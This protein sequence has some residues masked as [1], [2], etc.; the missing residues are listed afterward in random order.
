MPPASPGPSAAPAAG[1]P[2]KTL[3]R[4]PSSSLLTPAYMKTDAPSPAPV[5]AAAAA[6]A[7]GAPAAAV[8][9]VEASTSVP[10]P[11]MTAAP[12]SVVE[13]LPMPAARK[14]LGA[15]NILALTSKGATEPVAENIL[16]LTR[17][18][19]AFTLGGTSSLNARDEQDEDEAVVPVAMMA[20]ALV[21]EDDDDP[22]ADYARERGSKFVQL[23]GK[24]ADA[25]SENSR[26]PAPALSSLQ[27]ELNEGSV[28]LQP[29][30]PPPMAL[31]LPRPAPP[32][33][34]PGPA[35]SVVAAPAPATAVV[36]VDAR[37]CPLRG[38]SDGLDVCMCV[39]VCVYVG[40]AV[41][42][43]RGRGLCLRQQ[44]P[45]SWR[46]M[47]PWRSCGRCIAQGSPC[48]PSRAL[49]PRRVRP[50]RRQRPG[51]TPRPSQPCPP[52]T[53]PC[54]NNNNNNNSLWPRLQ[55]QRQPTQWWCRSRRGWTM[56]GRPRRC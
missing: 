24:G 55:R 1:T 21:P 5:A 38:I 7:T 20:A 3:P 28:V 48:G 52:T 40:S 19:P 33:A 10:T 54:N 32:V 11:A 41:R 22:A 8:A 46:G 37:P 2:A 26:R 27:A 30:R 42:W 4:R 44:R 56:S 13:P 53:C 34:A 6:A 36:E 15:N 18:L 17:P 50:R 45:H 12:A 35:P 29:V 25:A 43:R 51:H 47:C 16:E 23:F 49:C 14:P 31:P 39:C 9:A